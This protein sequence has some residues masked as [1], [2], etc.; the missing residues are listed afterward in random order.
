LLEIIV[1]LGEGATV[2]G[3]CWTSLAL[4]SFETSLETGE[5]KWFD[6]LTATS[7]RVHVVWNLDSAR[8]DQRYL[9]GSVGI[10]KEK[11]AGDGFDEHFGWVVLIFLVVL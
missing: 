7:I 2:Q 5:G 4:L 3:N 10:A 6:A 9:D 1:K 11:K 8:I